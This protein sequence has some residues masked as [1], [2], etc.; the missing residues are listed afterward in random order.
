M[1]HDPKPDAAIAERDRERD[2]LYL[3]TNPNDNQPVWSVEDLGRELEAFDVID[4]VNSLQ[5]AGLVN[6][7]SDG[8][9]FATRATVRLIR[10]VGQN[11]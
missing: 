10:T 4:N 1:S 9:V 5:R 11:L 8:Y 3:L 7:T 2:I 6:H